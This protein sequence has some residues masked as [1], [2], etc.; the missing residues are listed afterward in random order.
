MKAALNLATQ[1][2]IY[3]VLYNE[4]QLYFDQFMLNVFGEVAIYSTGKVC[5][6][7]GWE[8]ET[9]LMTLSLA[10]KIYDCYQTLL[11]TIMDPLS[12]SSFP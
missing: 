5:F 10:L 12:W 2:T 8:Y 9:F 11:N 6:N 7:V 3:K 4:L 1:L